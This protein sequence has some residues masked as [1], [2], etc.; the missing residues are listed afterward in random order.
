[1]N[2]IHVVFMGTPEFAV[3]VLQGL[4]EDPRIEVDMV[5]TQPDRPANRGK[6]L[7]P[8]PVKV[9]AEKLSLT[10]VQP[11][12][13][14]GDDVIR[15]IASVAPDFIIVVAYG[16]ILGAEILALAKKEV[17]NLHASLL[18]KYRGA[19]PIQAA[20]LAGEKKTGV[21][22]MGVRK[23]MDSGPVYRSFSTPADDKN[24]IELSEELTEIGTKTL[25]TV[26]KE[27]S[28][29]VPSEQDHSKATY[30]K[31]VD[32]TDGLISFSEMD[33][34]EILRRFKA[35]YGWPGVFAEW[36]GKRILL[37]GISI[38][39]VQCDNQSGAVCRV[40]DNVYVMAKNSSSIELKSVKLEG[41]KGL[42]ISEF[43]R[44]HRD[45][46]GSRLA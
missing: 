2:K 31:K 36:H 18:P 14:N 44:G 24:F 26:I 29:L 15:M 38:S 11:D 22:I 1:M 16:Q 30:C 19:S 32:K 34:N 23:K 7:T 35:F 43:L 28:K 42:P 9:L 40:D 3:P 39:D 41:K 25:L 17:L 46:V 6:I 20:I 37:S 13:V 8:P 12:N 5:V 10:I 27:F 45:F 33:S 21:S 4:C